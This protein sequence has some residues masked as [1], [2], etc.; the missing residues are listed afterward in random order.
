VFAVLNLK[1]YGS[2][3][4]EFSV[5]GTSHQRSVRYI[6]FYVEAS[7]ILPA[8]YNVLYRQ[9]CWSASLFTYLPGVYL[10]PRRLP[11]SRPGCGVGLFIMNK[12][13]VSLFSATFLLTIA[14]TAAIYATSNVGWL[15]I[16]LYVVNFPL[17]VVAGPLFYALSG[18][19]EQLLG[20]ASDDFGWIIFVA[21]WIAVAALQL[22]LLFA[23]ALLVQHRRRRERASK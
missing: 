10:P 1:Q 7:Q 16:V 4:L 22:A 14:A 19:V 18:I 21:W 15:Y 13:F 8:G 11:T 17:S 3:I 6:Y 5:S 20:S 9:V 2:R 23:I 12:R